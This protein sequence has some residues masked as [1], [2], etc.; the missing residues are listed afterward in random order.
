MITYFV[1]PKARQ[2]LDDQALYI[3]RNS[4]L[5]VAHRFLDSAYET[6]S[7][8]ASRPEIGWQPRLKH[9]KLAGLRIFR[10]TGFKRILIFYRPAP[11]RV[12]ILRVVHASKDLRR[13]IGREGLE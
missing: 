9:T 1:R 3:A 13:L 12:E 11:D 10:A 5:E 7:L 8:L 2:D 6:F 4:S